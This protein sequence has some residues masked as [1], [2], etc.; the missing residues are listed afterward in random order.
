MKERETNTLLSKKDLGYAIYP[1]FARAEDHT[2]V[3]ILDYLPSYEAVALPVT[4]STCYHAL[5]DIAR[6]QKGESVPIQAASADRILYSRNVTFAQSIRR[7]TKGRGVNV[8][9]N[10]LEGQSLI[11]G[12]ESIADFRCFVE[13]RTRDT[14]SDTSSLPMLPFSRNVTFSA[15]DM[16]T[17]ARHRPQTFKKAM[18]DTIT[19]CQE[20]RFFPA[21]PLHQFCISDIKDA[22]RF[23][24]SGKS[25]GKIVINMDKEAVV[26]VCAFRSQRDISLLFSRLPFR[27][28]RLS[29]SP[30]IRHT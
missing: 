7:V 19:L 9:L 5:V 6:L 21:R 22:F 16:T 15:V 25:T 2:T 11:A 20:G 30:L 12:F 24:R 28:N 13:N 3:E 18:E 4:F 17:V 14:H 10:S 27:P 29:L 1:T 23:L 26:P 8:V